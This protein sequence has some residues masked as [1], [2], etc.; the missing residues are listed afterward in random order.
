MPL[1]P[2]KRFLPLYIQR[3]TDMRKIY[4][5][6]QTYERH[7]KTLTEPDKTGMLITDYDDLGLAKQHF[8]A[9]KNVRDRLAAIIDLT[10]AS[11][12]VA[13]Q[14][15]LSVNSRYAVYWAAV[16][17]RQSLERRVNL[18]FKDNI[19]RYISENTR[20][21]IARDS[22][23]NPKIQ[24]IF[25]ELFIVLRYRSEELRIKFSDIEKF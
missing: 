23:I 9:R 13:F 22:G 16:E 25:G 17:S 11:H 6:S 19:R 8:A 5:V 21:H 14:R 12:L 3:F 20:W 1:Q 15:T 10:N 24:A 4:L 18:H 2:F 7:V